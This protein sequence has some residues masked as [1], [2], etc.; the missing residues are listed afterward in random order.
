[1]D[2]EAPSK[3]ESKKSVAANK[4]SQS[5]ARSKKISKRSTWY[6]IVNSWFGTSSS[7]QDRDS[8]SRHSHN[9]VDRIEG[10]TILKRRSIPASLQSVRLGKQRHRNRLA[11]HN[12]VNPIDGDTILKKRSVD[13]ENI[14]RFTKRSAW[15]NIV[16]SWFADFDSENDIHITR[17]HSHNGVYT[18][19][20]DTILKKRSVG[21]QNAKGIAKRSNWYDIVSSW[22]ADEDDS[23]NNFDDTRLRSHNGVDTIEGDF[24]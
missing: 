6:D 10:D 3:V 17:S 9:V 5:A 13:G 22:F 4:L 2:S 12:G 20:G 8:S 18:I 21:D 24:L 23:E 1:M 7:E 11:S 14:A 19:E 15:Y 16:S